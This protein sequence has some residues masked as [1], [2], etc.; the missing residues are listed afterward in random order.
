MN[1]YNVMDHAGWVEKNN[2]ALNRRNEKRKGWKK[3]PESLNLFQ[4]QVADILG[5]VGGG[6]Y[7][8]PILHEKIDWREDQVS[9]TWKGHHDL[10]TYD[11]GELT[12]LVFLCHEARIRVG[13]HPIFGGAWGPCLRL[14][15]TPRKATG[16][17]WARHPN[18]DEAVEGFRKYLPTDHRILKERVDADK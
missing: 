5:I 1:T 3:L 18:L 13:I 8:A 6:I 17:M 11:F 7:N 15:F 12:F 14:H 4:Q 16:D 9:V 2:I 10:A